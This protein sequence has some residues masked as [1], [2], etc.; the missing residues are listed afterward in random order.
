MA[1][2]RVN[3]GADGTDGLPSCLGM[4][5]GAGCAEGPRGQ[6]CRGLI[7]KLSP[8]LNYDKGYS[9]GSNGGQ[10]FLLWQT[11]LVTGG[12][13]A[14]GSRHGAEKMGSKSAWQHQ[15]GP[16]LYN[17]SQRPR[18]TALPVPCSARSQQLGP[19][20]CQRLR[21]SRAPFPRRF[22]HGRDFT[23]HEKH[24]RSSK[25]PSILHTEMYISVFQV[26]QQR[27][28]HSSPQTSGLLGQVKNY[29]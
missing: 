27:A 28:W 4:A 11:R 23:L 7:I 26:P 14:L 8:I 9:L 21:G 15:W 2:R 25:I 6:L 20:N 5:H 17:S 10:I 3:Q 16:P 1:H 19:P 18:D 29:V 24:T 12:R 13:P 22:F